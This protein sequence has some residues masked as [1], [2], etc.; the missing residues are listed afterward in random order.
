MTTTTKKI[1]ETVPMEDKKQKNIRDMSNK[2]QRNRGG[3]TKWG[4]VTRRGN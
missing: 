1:F 2:S 4:R 3:K